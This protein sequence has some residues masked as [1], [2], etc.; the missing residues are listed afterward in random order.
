[1]LPDAA[2]SPGRPSHFAVDWT[3]GWTFPDA[4]SPSLSPANRPA[5]NVKSDKT[6]SQFKLFFCPHVTSCFTFC[7]STAPTMPAASRRMK[8]MRRL[9]KNWGNRMNNYL[10]LTECQNLTDHKM[11]Y[12]YSY[13]FSPLN[14]SVITVLLLLLP[15]FEIMKTISTT[16]TLSYPH[17]ISSPH[18][19]SLNYQGTKHLF[20]S[21]EVFPSSCFHV[22]F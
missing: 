1:M 5:C 17:W 6:Y 13:N 9:M 14:P 19:S 7:S 10:S 4:P 8:I 20:V 11:I 16:K 21:T 3:A 15:L 12:S 18:P 2:V 22:Y